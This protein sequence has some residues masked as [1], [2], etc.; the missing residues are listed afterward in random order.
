MMLSRKLKHVVTAT[1]VAAL[2]AVGAVF[3]LHPPAVNPE[4]SLALG[5]LLALGLFSTLLDFR[6]TEG[7][8][9]TSVDFIP[10]LGAVLLIG[11]SY[12]LI[13]TAVLFVFRHFLSQRRGRSKPLHKWLFNTSQRL[14]AVSV[15]GLVFAWFG[16]SP[17]LESIQ[18]RST[19]PPFLLGVVAYFIVNACAVV[20]VISISEEQ[21]FATVWRNVAGHLIIFD[22]AISPLAYLFA[23]FYVLWG[24]P[25]VLLAIMPLIGLRYSYGVNVEL[26]QLNNDLL[27]VLVKTIEARDPYT[28]G[29][30]LRVAERSRRIAEK[31]GL[32]RK[33][34]GL[35]ETGALLHDIGKIDMAYS[36]ILR[37]A[38]P[39]TPEQRELIRAHPDKG[40]A[41]VSSVRSMDNKVLECIRHHHEWLDG[42]GY[43][44]GLSDRAIPIGARIIMV[45]DS[46]DA[47]ATDRPYRAALGR[48]EIRRELV[49][50]TGTQFDPDVVQATL[51]SGIL[52][53][54]LQTPK[55]PEESDGVEPIRKVIGH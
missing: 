55:A 15:F 20:Y 5:T 8:S 2:A 48:E 32:P 7:G 43:P 10:L 22:V 29:H 50:N 41:I 9:T 37:Q 19:F 28:S 49:N 46:I 31:I 27:R 35:I 11:P 24:A 21:A 38:G 23:L 42:S 1:T 25:T 17:S 54:L 14:L 40:V 33:L 36:E 6:I 18:F 47:M 16:G 52:E 53:D 26:Q 34:V 39:L 45:S 44:V 30:S 3:V 51:E 12:A 13:V 4:T